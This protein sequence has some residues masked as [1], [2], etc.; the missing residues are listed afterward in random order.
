MGSNGRFVRRRDKRSYSGKLNLRFSPEFHKAIAIEAET[1]G[2]SLND[3]I[4]A[5]LKQTYAKP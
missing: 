2:K 1:T 5:A 3:V 4:I